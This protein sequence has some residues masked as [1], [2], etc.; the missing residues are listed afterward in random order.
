MS[1]H[2]KTAALAIICG[3]V[4]SAPIAADVHIRYQVEGGEDG[5]ESI[6]IRD[7]WIRMDQAGEDHWS[8]FS[9]ADQTM[10]IINDSRREYFKMDAETVAA[11]GDLDK[12]IER[13]MEQALAEMPP[14]QRE[15]M[16]GMM[17]GMMRG[18]MEQARAQMPQ[19]SVRETGEIREIAGFEC[20]VTEILHDERKVIETCGMDPAEL[21]LPPADLAAIE[22]MQQFVE[23]LAVHVEGLLGEGFMDMSE[24]SLEQ[25][26]IETR[27]FDTGDR[28]TSS[29]LES[30]S[31]AALEPGF[32]VIPDGYRQQEIQMPEL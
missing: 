17:Q 14:A 28:V 9:S 32:F 31:T 20:R 15:Q 1:N 16:R 10:Y 6:M 11:I 25:F 8:L 13:Q 7:G 27:Y 3:L 19:Q 29:R 22:G 12:L 4:L 26:P 18:A 2:Y 24:L 21:D 23:N 5:L 30:L